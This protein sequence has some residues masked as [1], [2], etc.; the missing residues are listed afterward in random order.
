M[1]QLH[2]IAAV[3]DAITGMIEVKPQ[4]LQLPPLILR[5]V[6]FVGDQFSVMPPLE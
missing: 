6:F 5:G 1:G 2:L 3:T 4:A